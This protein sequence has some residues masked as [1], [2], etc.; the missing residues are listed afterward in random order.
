MNKEKTLNNIE[1][2]IK[3]YLSKNSNNLYTEYLNFLKDYNL[4]DNLDNEFNFSGYILERFINDNS[5]KEDLIEET[6]LM[7]FDQ[8]GHYCF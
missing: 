7:F 4:E 5:I 3:S 1:E 8:W 6:T 2:K